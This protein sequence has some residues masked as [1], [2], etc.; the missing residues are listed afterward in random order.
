MIQAVDAVVYILSLIAWTVA[1]PYSIY[2]MVAA[3]AGAEDRR[4]LHWRKAGI[5]GLVLLSS[6]LLPLVVWLIYPEVAA[7]W[8]Q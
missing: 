3:L 1:V 8:C 5:G 2:H 6:F 4:E 7:T